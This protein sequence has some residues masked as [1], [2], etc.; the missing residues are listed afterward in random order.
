MKTL[1]SPRMAYL[2][3]KWQYSTQ[4]S[5][6]YNSCIHDLSTSLLFFNM[7]VSIARIDIIVIILFNPKF[8]GFFESIN[9]VHNYIYM[10]CT[11]ISHQLVN[12]IRVFQYFKSYQDILYIVVI[13]LVNLSFCWSLFHNFGIGFGLRIIWYW[14]LSQDTV[15]CFSIRS[16]FGWE[17]ADLESLRSIW[18][19]HEGKQNRVFRM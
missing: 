9:C 13:F 15:W 8:Q 10:H 6:D 5:V 1:W 14:F 17:V 7:V 4:K 19:S 16:K 2:C 18:L 3:S 12:N 11:V